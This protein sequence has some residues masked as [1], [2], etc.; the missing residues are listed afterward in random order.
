MH[1]KK[2]CPVDRVKCPFIFLTQVIKEIKAIALAGDDHMIEYNSHHMGLSIC[3]LALLS[4][5][6]DTTRLRA[7][8][9]HCEK[10]RGQHSPEDQAAEEALSRELASN[11]VDQM[12]VHRWV[13]HTEIWLGIFLSSE[14]EA[15]PQLQRI[16]AALMEPLHFTGWMELDFLMLVWV[17][18]H[19][20]AG[21]CRAQ[22]SRCGPGG[23]PQMWPGAPLC[24]TASESGAAG[25][26]RVRPGIRHFIAHRHQP[27]EPQEAAQR[28]AR[29]CCGQ[30]FSSRHEPGAQSH[31]AEVHPGILFPAGEVKTFFG[32]EFLTCVLVGKKPCLSTLRLASAK[33]PSARSNTSS[34]SSHPSRCWVGWHSA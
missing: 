5:C 4:D 7:H 20:T 1:C 14:C 18:H 21:H 17:I 8:M 6:G 2:H 25:V 27:W 15:I 16:I 23:G 11:L 26:G 19:G 9:Q 12:G 28:I 32:T 29:K 10:M 22:V 30:P 13:D 31:S 24:G 34:P 33:F 3:S